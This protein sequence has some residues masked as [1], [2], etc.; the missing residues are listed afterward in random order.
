MVRGIARV[1]VAGAIVAL[2]PAAL[3]SSAWAQAVNPAQLSGPNRTAQLIAGAKKE[4]SLTLYS[5]APVP[6]T[7]ALGAAFKKKYGVTVNVWRGGS[8]AILQRAVTEARA[9]QNLVDVME[10]AGPDME[11][12]NREK[13]LQPVKSP[14]Y[15]QLMPEAVKPGRPWVA[16][17]LSIFVTA[18]NT[19]L[20][21]A[22]QIPKTYAGF[23][24][25]FWKGR[26]GVE[27]DDSNWLM[28]LADAMGEKKTIALFRS[29]VAKNG[30]SVRK[31]HTLL[32]NLVASGEVP[33]TFTGYI[34]QIE[35]LKQ[36]GAP[37]AMDFVD[38][39]IAMP[40]AAAVMAK[41]PHPYAA[42][43]FFDFYLTDGQKILAQ[44]DYVPTN[45]N[46]QRLPP[47]VK[48]HFMDV[49]QYLDEN[50]KWRDL[51]KQIFSGDP[52]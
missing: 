48:L 46:E 9:G 29:I 23:A 12:A 5:S 19:N 35:G 11:A 15:A 32:A 50:A 14:V 45:K 38:P 27:A 24:A 21:R 28:A 16:G 30:M 49:G 22:N 8:E 36:A 33:L 52:G 10:T 13:L 25:P 17:R 2:A 42:V 41:A 20:I 3:V 26:L 44:H 6:V 1:L 39:V 51:Y 34:E 4:G 43:L 18:Y 37:I 40:T 31:G 7:E 47:G